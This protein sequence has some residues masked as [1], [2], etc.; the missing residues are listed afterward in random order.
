MTSSA[1]NAGSDPRW[2]LWQQ[3]VELWLDHP[4]LGIGLGQ[5]T[6]FSHG[7]TPYVGDGVHGQ[8]AHNTFLSFAAETGAVGALT[9]IAVL[10]FPVRMLIRSRPF[11]APERALL[12]GVAVLSGMMMTLNLQNLRYVWVYLALVLVASGRNAARSAAQSTH[13]VPFMISARTR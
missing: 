5:F 12:I 6:R 13:S 9:F 10:V 3:A 4:V 8:V 2:N 11:P 7:L 1:A